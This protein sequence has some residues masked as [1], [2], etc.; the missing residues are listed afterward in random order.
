MVDPDHL[1]SMK[2]LVALYLQRQ[3]WGAAAKMMIRAAKLGHATHRAQML[4]QAGMLALERLG[5]E[6]RAVELLAETLS[7]DPDHM[8]AGLP[9]AEIYYRKE[10]W[11]RL[12]PVLQLINQLTVFCVDGDDSA[13]LEGALET[14]IDCFIGRH[15]RVFISHKMFEAVD[16]LFFHQRFHIF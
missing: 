13:K 14:V 5:D 6:A 9:L 4:H 7:H 15:D 12:E 3:E 2:Q 16:A 1:E 10:R 8:G 11:R